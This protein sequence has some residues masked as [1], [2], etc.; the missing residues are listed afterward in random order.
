MRNLFLLDPSIVFLNHGSFG[1]CPAE[2]FAAYQEWQ[3]ELEK[4]PVE[5]LG[6]RSAKLLYESRSVLGAYLG[7]RPEHLVYLANATSGVNT[8]ARSLVL[9]PGDKVLT[10]DH[11]Y[12]ACDNVW[13]FVC[14]QTGARMIRVKIPLPF[15]ADEFLD[16]VWS[17]VTSRTR[18]IFL[19]HIT[20]TT[21]LIFPIAEL[22]RR[23]KAAGIYTFIDGAHAPSQI[24]LDLDLLQADFYIGNCHK[25]LCAPKGAA[26]L[27]ARPE[28]HA[29]LDAPI[30]S[31]GYSME[32][33]GHTGFDAYTGSTLLERRLQWQGTRDIASFLSVPAAIRFQ[34]EH[35]WDKI[36]RDCHVLAKE[37]LDKICG[38][39][40]LEPVCDEKD[41]GQ[42]VAIPVPAMN[43]D[44]LKNTLFEHHRIEIPVTTHGDRLFIRLSLQ[45]YNTREDTDA[46]VRA[47]REIY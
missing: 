6:R 40:G 12:G 32:I 15:K 17:Q 5:F 34:K 22:C 3:R 1:A 41:F 44:S 20:S 39:T 7:A 38:L 23:A 42:M 31:W 35:N 27:Y 19:S 10:T 28:H 4:N 21:A 25:W 30:I 24:P 47:V 8:V 13:E 36:R 14:K 29:L 11:E 18:V 37:T 33:A 16:R 26:F 43:A 45:G 9:K 46:L 2:V